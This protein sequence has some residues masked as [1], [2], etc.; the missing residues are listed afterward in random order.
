[1]QLEIL[2]AILTGVMD[3]LVFQQN[4]EKDVEVE[5]KWRGNI[6]IKLDLILQ[7]QVEVYKLADIIGTFE[8]E[9]CHP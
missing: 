7:L 4:R 6:D 5:A 2:I 3:V 9:D 1:M 8:R